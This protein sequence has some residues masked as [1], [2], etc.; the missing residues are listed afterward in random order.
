MSDQEQGNG[1]GRAA[2]GPPEPEELLGELAA[3]RRRTR[4]ARHAYWFPLVLFGLLSCAAV[5]LYAAAAEPH[6]HCIA[7]MPSGSVRCPLASGAM[8]SGANSGSEPLV[9]GGT[10]IGGNGFYL[11]WY[12]LVALVVGYLLTVLW[13]RRHARR[14]GVQTSARGYLVTSVVLTVL[15]VVIPPLASQIGFVS[16]LWHDIPGDLLIR[17]TFAFLIIAAGLW[18][19][20]WAERSVALVIT[21]AVYT[22]T[23][24][25]ASLYN[26]ENVLFRLGWRPGF[27]DLSLTV[28]PNV[29]LPAAVLLIAGAVAFVAQRPRHQVRPA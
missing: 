11:G 21:A 5:P 2:M 1:P 18:A 16:R 27:G 4:S 7:V 29:L 25:L 12:W 9:L 22:G 28:L 23:A 19:L 8:T 6:F 13:Y 10:P 15:A 17:G 26:V 24:L 20:A 14:A 3:M